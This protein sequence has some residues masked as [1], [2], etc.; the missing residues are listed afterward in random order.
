MFEVS[1]KNSL[2]VTLVY[3]A[4]RKEEDFEFKRIDRVVIQKGTRKSKNLKD[5]E[6]LNVAFFQEKTIMVELV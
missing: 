4:P 1:K 6:T 5:M 3:L 2:T